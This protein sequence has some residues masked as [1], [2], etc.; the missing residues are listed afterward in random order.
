[1]RRISREYAAGKSP[2]KIAAGINADGIPSPAGGPRAARHPLDRSRG[3]HDPDAAKQ[4]RTV[5]ARVPRSNLPPDELTRARGLIHRLLGG[6]A[7]VEKDGA[8]R[9]LAV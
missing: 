4:Y 6:R 2:R 5:I 9:V 8:G 3:A 7:T 1:V